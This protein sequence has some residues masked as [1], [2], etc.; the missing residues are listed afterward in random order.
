M[1]FVQNF[2]L[3][4]LRS[5]HIGSEIG[6]EAKKAVPAYLVRRDG[7]LHFFHPHRTTICNG[8]PENYFS[9]LFPPSF[10]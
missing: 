8:M 2:W 7:R 10:A 5:L 4:N 6:A 9:E 3:C 1:V